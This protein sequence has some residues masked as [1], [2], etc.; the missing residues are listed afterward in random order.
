MAT[1]ILGLTSWFC[2]GQLR[3]KCPL[4]PHLKQLPSLCLLSLSCGV[5]NSWGLGERMQ[6][7]LVG[8]QLALGYGPEGQ[9]VLDEEGGFA[10]GFCD[11]GHRALHVLLKDANLSFLSLYSG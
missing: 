5:N 4:C 1:R 11:C 3:A 6:L 2:K 9:F 8:K 10:L 7:G